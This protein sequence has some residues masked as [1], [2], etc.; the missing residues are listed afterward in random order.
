MLS[1]VQL[2]QLSCSSFPFPSRITRRL[3]RRADGV[4]IRASTTTT[5]DDKSDLSVSESSSSSLL[6]PLNI[7]RALAGEGISLVDHYGRLQVSPEASSGEIFQAYRKRR[8]EI[9][10]QSLEESVIQKQLR[11]LQDSADMLTSEEERRMYDWS[12]LRLQNPGVEYIWPF[13]A[14]ITQRLSDSPPNKTVEDDEGN[15]NVAIFF[16]GWFIL[17]CVLNIV[18]PR[19]P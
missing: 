7:A 9:T 17:S 15:R 4:T 3:A 6:S 10:A 19:L 2:Q 1:T 11:D 8:S 12:L 16:L 5:N 13:E 14:D 18:L